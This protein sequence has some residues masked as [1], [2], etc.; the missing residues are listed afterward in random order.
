VSIYDHDNKGNPMT[1]KRAL[2]LVTR[3]RIT[4]ICPNEQAH[5]C[6]QGK[7]HK[8]RPSCPAKIRRGRRN[9]P[10]RFDGILNVGKSRL[11]FQQKR[12]E[13]SNP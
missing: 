12:L 6:Y 7:I 10:W 3:A 13:L 5:S 4:A 11:I 1:I 8:I 2:I 9:P